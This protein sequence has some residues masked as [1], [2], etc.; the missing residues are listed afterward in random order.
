MGC[1]A[2]ALKGG[3]GNRKQKVKKAG[4]LDVYL[5][6]APQV[7]HG[8][9]MQYLGV[10]EGTRWRVGPPRTGGTW[11]VSGLESRQLFGCMEASCVYVLISS[12][13][14]VDLFGSWTFLY[15]I[16]SYTCI[17]VAF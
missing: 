1:G 8:K 12:R 4:F 3:L 17:D 5:P 14:R 11:R 9:R 2:T 6:L 10:A 7:Y 13:W 16:Q 15:N